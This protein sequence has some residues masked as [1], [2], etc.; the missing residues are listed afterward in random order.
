[1]REKGLPAEAI[2]YYHQALA[3]D[4]K[5]LWVHSHLGEALLKTGQVDE[6]IKYI[7]AEPMREMWGTLHLL[8]D[9]LAAKGLEDEAIDTYTYA[10]A[11]SSSRWDRDEVLGRLLEKKALR[12]QDAGNW[13]QAVDCYRDSLYHAPPKIEA[14][15][16]LSVCLEHEELWTQ[17]IADL[18]RDVELKLDDKAARD[19][20][21]EAILGRLLERKKGSS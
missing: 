6:A 12:L 13:A 3:L 7:R 9:A 11:R 4:P 17:R 5:L 20:L 10:I 16:A 14:L 15:K 8:G 19:S 1:M 2:P 18:L 21:S